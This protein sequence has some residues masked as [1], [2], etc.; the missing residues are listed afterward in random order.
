MKCRRD[1]WGL[2][3]RD[4]SASLQFKDGFL[5]RWVFAV[6]FGMGFI[7]NAYACHAVS[8]QILVGAHI[9]SMNRRRG[10]SSTERMPPRREQPSVRN[11]G[12]AKRSSPRVNLS[13]L[14]CLLY[15][16]LYTIPDIFTSNR[17]GSTRRLA[18]EF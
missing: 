17:D 10:P 16:P 1:V 2:I 9:L 5:K 6:K 12:D 7:F 3:P 13:I 15:R 18:P 8:I 4:Q 14:R 11:F